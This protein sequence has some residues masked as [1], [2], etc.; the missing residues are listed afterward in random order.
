MKPGTRAGVARKLV[1]PEIAASEPKSLFGEN[2][3]MQLLDCAGSGK[4]R[5]LVDTGALI[6][7]LTNREIA[8]E[9]TK[10]L[11]ADRFAAVIYGE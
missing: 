6:T 10:R 7:G 1:N 4:F 5:A 9:L 3:A 8:F 11:P 2:T